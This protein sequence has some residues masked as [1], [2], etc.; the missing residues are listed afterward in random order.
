MAS[1]SD[2]ILKRVLVTNDDGIDAPG[3]EVAEEVAGFIAEE[4]W[5][6]APDSD[7]SGG[8]RQIN[9]HK[10]L[11]VEQHD[12]RRFS[13]SG[14]PADC[15]MIGVGEILKNLDIDLVLSGVNA[16][17]NIGG[18]VGFSGTVGAA[19]T[20]D[21][22]GLPGVALSQAWKDR[23]NIPW[24]TSRVWLP[25]VLKTLLEEGGFPWK[26][27]P[28]INVPSVSSDAVKGTSLSVQG[29][30]TRVSPAIEKRS[31]LREKNYFWLYIAKEQ[32]S[33]EENEDIAVL[34]S[35]RVS[36]S[37]LTRNI[38]DRYATEQLGSMFSNKTS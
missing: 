24:E 34:R 11:R 36:V 9:L 18:D 22:L 31:D 17:V 26:F 16:G 5:T 3:L 30:S 35:C 7:C 28:N 37:L 29:Q 33:P 27:V 23:G 38:T 2:K 20:A 14:S 19:M 32:G 12:D 15:V 8:S 21:V 25:K 4:V 1:F 13:V 6:V 10:P